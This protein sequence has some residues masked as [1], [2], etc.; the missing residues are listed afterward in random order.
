MTSPPSSQ[1]TAPPIPPMEEPLNWGGGGVCVR[2]LSLLPPHRSHRG[3]LWEGKKGQGGDK[4]ELL[5]LSLAG[6]CPRWSLTAVGDHGGGSRGWDGRA[7]A[8]PPVL[9]GEASDSPQS[10]QSDPPKLA[11]GREPTPQKKR[12]EQ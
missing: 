12:K 8:R 3:G 1:L 10:T 9:W 2:F 7:P 11:P 6:G 4:R 5:S